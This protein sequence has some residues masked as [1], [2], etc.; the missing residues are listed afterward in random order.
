MKSEGGKAGEGGGRSGGVGVANKGGNMRGT[1]KEKGE[2]KK[3]THAKGMA[4]E[5]KFGLGCVQK[6]S[7]GRKVGGVGVCT[8]DCI[9]RRSQ[10]V[11]APGT[12]R[13]GGKKEKSC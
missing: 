4:R 12:S 9:F 2:K 7:G 11:R 5:G 3:V 6:G 8:V 1:D 13:K 10:S